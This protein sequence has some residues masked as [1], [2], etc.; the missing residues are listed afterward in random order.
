MEPTLSRSLYRLLGR[1]HVPGQ[2]R[3]PRYHRVKGDC[4][5]TSL[6]CLSHRRFRPGYIEKDNHI[7]QHKASSA[8]RKS[9]PT[10]RFQSATKVPLRHATFRPRA[11]A[12]FLVQIARFSRGHHHSCPRPLTSIFD[13]SFDRQHPH[14]ALTTQQRSPLLL[15]VFALA[16]R[17]CLCPNLIS[18]LFHLIACPASAAHNSFRR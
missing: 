5:H 4:V 12:A 17:R 9:A 13:F 6:M 11:T 14:T 7:L 3:L 15:D 18:P 10:S 1:R 16:R 2:T 8:K